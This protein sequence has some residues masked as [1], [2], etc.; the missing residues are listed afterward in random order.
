MTH[1][2]SNDVIG[3]VSL[4]ASVL[5]VLYIVGYSLML[6]YQQQRGKI[7]SD[8]QISA[9]FY[10]GI[11]ILAFGYILALTDVAEKIFNT[12]YLLALILFAY[13]FE[14]RAGTAAQAAINLTKGKPK[15]K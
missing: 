8:W 3:L 7:R 4:V 1:L 6:Y 12:A 15:K 14:K 11:G 2:I 5:V 10:V 13:G 9:V